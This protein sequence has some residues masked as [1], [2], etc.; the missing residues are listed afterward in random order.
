MNT[1]VLYGK[2]TEGGISDRGSQEGAP[3]GG[4][5]R[6]RVRTVP[7]NCAGRGE[8]AQMAG[9]DGVCRPRSRGRE[10]ERPDVLQGWCV[11]SLWGLVRPI[12]STTA[13]SEEWGSHACV[14]R[15]ESATRSVWK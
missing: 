11:P 7:A 15:A 10:A 14:R 4:E 13:V 12:T 8:A 2:A 6:V 1:N 3:Y 9:T 5:L